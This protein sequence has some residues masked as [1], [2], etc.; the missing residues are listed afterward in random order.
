MTVTS[1]KTTATMTPAPAAGCGRPRGG[2]F[3]AWRALAAFPAVAGSVLFMLV[4]T[5]AL[6]P[7]QAPVFLVWLGAAGV[8]STRA[9]ERVA[10]R[11]RGF[12]PLSA[13]QREVLDPVFAAAVA[14]CRVRAEQVDWYLHAGGQ[15]TACVAGRRSLAVTEGALKAFVAGGLTHDHLQAIL[16]HELAHLWQKATSGALAIGWLA[17]PGRLALR[18]VFR[19]A[20]ALSGRRRLGWGSGPLLLVGGGIALGSAV[21][22]SQWTAALML[23][24]LGTAMLGTPLLDAAISRTAER[25]ADRYAAEVGAGPDL[26]QALLAISGSPLA[27]R[28]W[29][30]GLMDS[31]PSVASRVR[32]LGID[33]VA[34]PLRVRA[35][36]SPR[37]VLGSP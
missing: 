35:R 33:Q 15:P 37:R 13:R 14:R 12:R 29:A 19:L 31:H 1:T 4:L 17:A 24:G 16:C 30:W 22:H 26:A 27:R 7:W 3:G 2:R 32:S 6:S 20:C 28:R 10:M 23:A 18:L 11:A 8:F 34:A 5:A 21:Q 9:G 36:R 25:A